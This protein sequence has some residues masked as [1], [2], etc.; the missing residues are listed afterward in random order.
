MDELEST[1]RSELARW[2]F[3]N[4][5]RLAARITEAH[6][7][8]PPRR[9]ARH[10][11]RGPSAGMGD[12]GDHLEYLTAAVAAGAPALFLDYIG[13][14]KVVLAGLGFPEK[15]LAKSLDATRSVLESEL[16]P[17]PWSVAGSLLDEAARVLPTLPRE[18]PS[19]I[20]K[21]NPHTELAARYVGALLAGD[22]H[23]ASKMILDTVEGGIPVGDIHVHVMSPA[24]HE[25]GRLWQMNRI[26]VA[27]EHYCTAVTQQVMSRLYPWIFT[28]PR[29]GLRLIATTV[30]GELH[31]LG[32]RM[33]ADF[34][35]LAGWDAYYL[36]A[37]TPLP[38]LVAAIVER[39]PALVV[40]SATMTRHVAM[41]GEYV[42]GIRARPEI[43]EV[44][45]LVGGYPFN[46]AA[47]LWKHVGADGCARLPDV[48]VQLG[49]R[50]AAERIHR[51]H[52]LQ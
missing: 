45:I 9:G 26:S 20:F 12:P 27:Q 48:T 32:A 42:R 35:E 25:I 33:V 28:T 34:F 21:A 16:A 49:R 3:M 31:E 52:I 30:E 17:A 41:V 19:P 38:D 13:W 46:V 29:I 36:G 18:A 39:R 51:E 1:I 7:G 44:P 5:P 24:Q 40:I 22:R 2:L 47:D 50:L 11:A 8:R 14:A 23:L 4:Q 6:H 37:S 10:S 43:A 15:H